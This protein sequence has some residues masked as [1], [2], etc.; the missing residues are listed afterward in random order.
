MNHKQTFTIFRTEILH[1]RTGAGLKPVEHVSHYPSFTRK[2]DTALN[3]IL[4]D[5]A[6]NE[7][8]ELAEL[9]MDDPDYQASL[10]RAV[11]HVTG[12]WEIYA[13]AHTEKPRGVE[14]LI[15]C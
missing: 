5:I 7:D 9:P 6:E 12:T 1:K 13:G 3:E 10:A 2:A 15:S 11:N 4:E 8:P 14:P